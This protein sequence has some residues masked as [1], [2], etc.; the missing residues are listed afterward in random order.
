MTDSKIDW[1]VEVIIS[2]CVLSTGNIEFDM[3]ILVVSSE[4]ISV[5]QDS[6][7]LKL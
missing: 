6:N 1:K 5:L 7:S 3:S 4:L 2:Y